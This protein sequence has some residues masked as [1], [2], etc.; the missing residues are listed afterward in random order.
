MP[1]EP[2]DPNPHAGDV[3]RLLN[4]MGGSTP[5]AINQLFPLVYDELRRVAGNMMRQRERP[6]HTLQP[7]ALVHEAYMRLSASPNENVRNRACFFA[8]AARAMRQA[9][10]EYARHKLAS[11]RGGRQV[12]VELDD[13][14][15]CVD[16]EL[17]QVLAVD[18]A[19]TELEK[20]DPQQAKLVEMQYFVGNSIEEISAATG[21]PERTAKRELQTGRLFLAEKLNAV[22]MK[23]K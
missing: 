3:T 5:E 21:L 16:I 7:T 1:M 12:K 22:G 15:S 10:V 11:K 19:L 20:L 9:L 23:L 6:G 8:V 2:P 14:M 18:E 4:E 13:A 17:D